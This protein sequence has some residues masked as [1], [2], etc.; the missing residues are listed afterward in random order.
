MNETL[1]VGIAPAVFDL[2]PGYRRAVVVA[3]AASNG[4]S[5]PTL[6]DLLV[7]AQENARRTFA[8]R[9][10][11]EDPRIGDWRR[12]FKAFGTDPTKQRP[13]VEALVRRAIG[14]GLSSINRIV[15][16]GTIIS[17]R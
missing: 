10:P 12:A 13:S 15:D 3:E 2:A 6:V 8:D 7:Q 17:L 5:P 11:A 9:P 1:T 14:K 4:P 16:I